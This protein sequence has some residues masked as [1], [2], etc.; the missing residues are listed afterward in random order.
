MPWLLINTIII[1]CGLFLS[2]CQRPEPDTE[3]ILAMYSI[4][5]EEKTNEIRIREGW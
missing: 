5:G 2:G 1:V 4:H 3:T